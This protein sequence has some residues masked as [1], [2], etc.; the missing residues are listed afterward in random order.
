MT[1]PHSVAVTARTLGL[2][3]PSGQRRNILTHINSWNCILYI[4]CVT[5][6]SIRSNQL[7][8]TQKGVFLEHPRHIGQAAMY[9]AQMYDK[10]PEPRQEELWKWVDGRIHP[11]CWWQ[12]SKKI[13]NLEIFQL[14]ES[15]F[16]WFFRDKMLVVNSCRFNIIPFIYIYTWTCWLVS[17][18][19]AGSLSNVLSLASTR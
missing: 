9:V 14:K 15:E 5:F 2:C 1:L 12:A 16:G 19:F 4:I 8:L 17:N 10:R 3:S 11:G 7:N 6:R 13:R 18:R